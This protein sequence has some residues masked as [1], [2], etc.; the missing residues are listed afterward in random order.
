MSELNDKPPKQSAEQSGLNAADVFARIPE[1][2]TAG[3]VSDKPAEKQANS[4]DKIDSKNLDKQSEKIAQEI[5]QHKSFGDK[6]DQRTALTKLFE[7]AMSKNRL[8]DL[9]DKTNERLKA[10]GYSLNAVVD[11]R[12]MVGGNTFTMDIQLKKDGKQVDELKAK[13]KVN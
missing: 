5:T 12:N 7:S 8:N 9:M 10:S 11:A 13:Q 6:D 1:S 2:P 3:K 4:S